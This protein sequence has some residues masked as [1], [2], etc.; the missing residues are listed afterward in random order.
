MQSC[1]SVMITHLQNGYSLG[2][3]ERLQL[4]AGPITGKQLH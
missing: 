3:V 4:P 2:L 1:R